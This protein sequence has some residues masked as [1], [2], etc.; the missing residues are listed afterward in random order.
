MVRRC[1]QRA[2][3]RHRS[4]HRSATPL[5]VDLEDPE[6]RVL[7]EFVSQSD[8][9]NLGGPISHSTVQSYDLK[10]VA[11]AVG[12][13]VSKE[14][15]GIYFGAFPAGCNPEAAD[16][17]DSPLAYACQQGNA[18]VVHALLA[19][20]ANPDA[21]DALSKR[22]ALMHSAYNG[23]AACVEALLDSDCA[24]DLQDRTGY[25]ALEVAKTQEVAALIR[26]KLAPSVKSATKT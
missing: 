21:G 3:N 2:R 23:R 18:D 24:L 1:A 15:E 7:V 10:A 8:Y 26:E 19:A 17:R 9:S 4:H 6:G 16:K 14:A 13:R 11:S 5:E 20:G 22:T 25:T 12:E